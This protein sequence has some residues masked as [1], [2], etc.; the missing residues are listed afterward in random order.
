MKI[1]FTFFIVILVSM[2]A[3]SQSRNT[4]DSKAWSKVKMDDRT[5]ITDNPE[6]KGYVAAPQVPT[7]HRMKG[8]EAVVYPN[9][10]PFPTTNSTQSE[11]S[12]D[13]NPLNSN[14]IFCSANATNNPVTTIYGT[15]VYYTTNAG[16]TWAGA[17]NPPFGTNSGDPAVS[18][19]TNGNFFVGFIDGGAN[20]GGQGVAVST[21]NGGN[22][23]RYVVAPKPAS[24]ADLLDKNHLVVDKKVGSPFENRVYAAWTAFVTGSPNENDIEV[25]YSTNNGQNWSASINISG[26]LNAGSHNQGINL[27]TGPNGEVYA[28]WAVY[29]QWA[30]GQYGEDAIAFNVSTDGGVTWGVPKKAYTAANFGIRGNLTSKASIRVASFPSMAVDRSGGPNNGHIYITW[31][32]RGVTP[33]GSDPDIVIMK[34]SDGGATWSTPK[35]VNDDPLN[36][37]KDQYYPWMTV[38][39]TTGHVYVAFYDSRNTTNDS[40]GVFLARS[41]DGANSFENIQVS[42]RNFKPKTISGLATGYQ[43]DYIGIA[44]HSNTVYPYWMEDRTGL[45]QGWMTKVT[46]GPIIEHPALSNTE[47]MTGPYPVGAKITSSLPLNPN[48]VLLYWGRNTGGAVTD[49]VIMTSAG[50]DSFTANIPGNGSPAT[51]YYYLYAEDNTGGYSTYPAG[52]PSNKFMFTA[53]TDSVLPVITHTPIGNQFRE[54]WPATVNSNV[55]DNIGVDS[56]KVEYKLKS[57]GQMRSFI[58]NSLGSG[59]YSGV[60]NIDTSLIA[61]G[62]TLFY[63]I[64]AVDAGSLHNTAYLPASGFFSFVFINDNILPVVTHTPLRNQPEIRWPAVVRA[65]ASDNMGIDYVK[66]EYDIRNGAL[67][68]NFNLNNVGGDQYQGTFNVDTSQIAVGDTVKYRLVV[69]DL[70]NAGNVVY[71]PATGSHSFSIINTLGLVLI[72]NDDNVVEERMSSPK[73]N[74]FPVPENALGASATLIENT[75]TAA[76]YVVDNVPFLSADTNSF[77]GYD[78]IA[79]AAGPKT[80]TIFES[81]PIRNAVTMFT[82]MGG[83]TFVEGGEVGWI[84]RYSSATSDKDPFF[85]RNVLHDS[86]W[87]SDI[88]S[89]ILRKR[90]PNHQLFNEPHSIPDS[91]AFNITTI[92]GRDAMR[93]IPN[94]AG[95]FKL[96]GWYPTYP[97]TASIIAFSPSNDPA[98]I[99]N[100]TYHFSISNMTNQDAAKKLIENGFALLTSSGGYIPVELLSFAASASN[101]NVILSWE[102][103]TE[104]NNSGFEVERKQ[105][106]ESFSKI[107]FVRGAGTSLLS[108]GYSFTDTNLEP[109]TY[110][111]RLRQ[112]DFDGSYKILPEVNVDI[113]LPYEY[114]LDQNYPNPFNPNTVIKYAVPQA[115]MV[116]IAVYNSLGEKVATIVNQIHEPGNFT[117]EL[118]AVK[119][120]SGVY[121]YR[122]ESGSFVSVKKMIVLK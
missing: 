37:A 86:S 112:L 119:L 88:S 20:D 1:R 30:A 12:V 111:Y 5:R 121:F 64:K 25:R 53:N 69:K 48:K 43:G 108:T 34:S 110:T 40:A 26:A 9:F 21:N 54:V 107:G 66:V 81:L 68:G 104:L 32:Q 78:V 19:G 31:P 7:Y 23:G 93:I 60:F 70:S 91:L 87:V 28:A 61:V 71:H 76:G 52:A 27:Q 4:V 115:G 80:T 77:A 98:E 49:S 82:L 56:V 106:S 92:G 62:D 57:N 67:V 29:D 55:T 46:F 74:T 84:Y 14:I 59:N 63:K 90:L 45:Y 44:A 41:I 51:Y 17:D 10:R 120:G 117:V 73:G 105:G 35:R 79:L 33:A 65:T 15:G 39:Q 122:M 118:N 116:N 6:Y 97:D 22:W 103:A 100:L 18:I 99:R 85:R 96:G 109:G 38:D 36:N 89:G 94:K 24:T 72:L 2:I 113:S 101:N 16:T 11:M 83:K 42:D 75:L 102:T 3:M 47:N 50:V 58:L 95:I 114:A 13:I 8:I